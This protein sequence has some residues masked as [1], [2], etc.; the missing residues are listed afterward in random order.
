[1][2]LLSLANVRVNGEGDGDENMHIDKT[3]FKAAAAERVST[4]RIYQW[5]GPWVSLGRTQQSEKALID[6]NSVRWVTR[7]TG[8]GG[9]LHGHDL[10]VS[11]ARPIFGDARRLRDLYRELVA[12]LI[13]ALRSLGIDA[14]LGESLESD[15]RPPSAD[16]FVRCSPNDVVER[17][18]K[19]K[20]IG[21]AMRV[22]RNAVLAQCSIPVGCPLIDPAKVFAE[23]HTPH[24]LPISIDDMVRALHSELSRSLR[25]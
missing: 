24:L 16:C 1:M 21:V 25:Q 15:C 8:G 3:M 5:E 7:P 18:S 14:A 6:P 4:A 11:I 23:P 20:L 22:T 12:P 2:S 13:L 9:V 19:E 10:T 17:S